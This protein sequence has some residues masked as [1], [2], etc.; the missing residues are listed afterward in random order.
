MVELV[1][2]FRKGIPSLSLESCVRGSQLVVHETHAYTTLVLSSCS[3]KEALEAV[4]RLRLLLLGPRH[5]RRGLTRRGRSLK[6]FNNNNKNN[7]KATRASFRREE[8]T[9]D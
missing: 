2:S 7:N 3:F 6:N 9:N 1:G 8:N 5:Y 4:W